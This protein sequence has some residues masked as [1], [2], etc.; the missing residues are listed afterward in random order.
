V[1]SFKLS[2]ANFK[3]ESVES[4]GE[5]FFPVYHPKT[6]NKQ[7]LGYMRFIYD[8][9]KLG[10]LEMTNFEASL[11]RR[12]LGIGGGT[13]ASDAQQLGQHGEGLKLSALVNRRHPHNYGFTVYSTGCKWTFG[14]N[15]DRKLNC[16]IQRVPRH[17][18]AELKEEAA[19]QDEK[20][21]SRVAEAR[22]WQDVSI[23]VGDAR[24]WRSLKGEIAMTA[25][26]PLVEFEQWLKMTID[27]SPPEKIVKTKAGD[28]ILD[29][30]YSNKLYLHGLLLPGGSKSGRK[31]T[32]GYNLR[33]VTTGRDRDA[34]S[35]AA[36]ES[37]QITAIWE[38]VLSE[39]AENEGTRPYLALY[40]DMIRQTPNKAADVYDLEENIAEHVATMLWESMIK[41]KT[42]GRR[43]FYYREGGNS[44][45]RGTVLLSES[46]IS[47][48][49][50]CGDY[51]KESQPS[52]NAAQVRAVVNLHHAL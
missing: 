20:G 48:I 50:G 12:H 9:K 28:L 3:V 23:V 16:R 44:H 17:E 22:V 21:T 36:A 38:Y 33:D 39:E 34:I 41:E 1:R 6:G 46:F 31:F 26:I 49:L 13:K 2:E 24:R 43:N 25:K 14:W 32:H 40:I 5:R 27:V 42:N 29:P 18:L 47:L 51:R 45:V 8:S 4:H 11:Q 10:S 19:E 52:S 15:V 37:E 30:A 35:D 7:L